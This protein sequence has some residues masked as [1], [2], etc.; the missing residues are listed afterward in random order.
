MRYNKYVYDMIRTYIY[1]DEQLEQR[2][3]LIHNK[4]KD[5]MFIYDIV[6]NRKRSIEFVFELN[7][8]IDLLKGIMKKVK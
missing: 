7:N 4:H 8:D 5:T 2:F 3:V 6:D 1:R